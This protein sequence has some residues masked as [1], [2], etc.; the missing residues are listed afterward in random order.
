MNDALKTLEQ[1]F[2]AYPN[3][4]VDEKTIVI[5]IRMLSDI[6]PN[7]LQMAVLQAISEYK[8]LPSPSEIREAHLALT[9][10]LIEQTPGEAW[11]SVEKAIAGEGHTKSPGTDF[12][13]RNPLVQRVVEMM[14]WRNLCMSDK[15]GV[16][17][18]QFMRMYEDCAKRSQS[19]E[20][21]LPEVRAYFETNV[22]KRLAETSSA[23]QGMQGELRR[24]GL[25]E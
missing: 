8:F 23:S 13:F 3:T 21:M 7:E 6:P 25:I 19:V 14:G 9:G 17:R 20:R 2:A 18:A 16:D 5:Y 12:R 1:L 11:G 22:Q 4:P 24:L 15:P 10:G